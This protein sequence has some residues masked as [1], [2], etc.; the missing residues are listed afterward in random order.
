[1]TATRNILNFEGFLIGTV[2]YSDPATAIAISSPSLRL[3]KDLF[4]QG[5]VESEAPSVGRGRRNFGR[6][7]Q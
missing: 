6:D 3:Q 7:L 5:K 2:T 4:Y 1:M